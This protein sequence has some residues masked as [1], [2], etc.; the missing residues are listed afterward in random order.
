MHEGRIHLIRDFPVLRWTLVKN[1]TYRWLTGSANC[2]ACSNCSR[3]AH[4]SN[5][6][7]CGVCEGRTR[8]TPSRTY[9]TTTPLYSNP[10]TSRPATSN[11][12]KVSNLK[13][14]VSSLEINLRSGPGLEFPILMTLTIGDQ[15]NYIGKKGDWIYV[16][17]EFGKKGYVHYKSMK[18]V[19]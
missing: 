19:E 1:S 4:C 16:Q 5:G 2:T 12:E 9:N 13:M 17:T 7:T 8:T 18:F 11:P 14:V 15:V 6:G 3:Y 10:G